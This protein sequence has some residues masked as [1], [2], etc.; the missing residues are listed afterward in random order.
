[1]A[2]S[3]KQRKDAGA[4][5]EFLQAV[6][7]G[8][9]DVIKI[10]DRDMRIQ[11]VN[12]AI[13]PLAGRSVRECVGQKC[14]EVVHGLSKP[15]S[16][17]TTMETFRTGRRFHSGEWMELKDGSRRFIEYATYPIK[18]ADGT[19]VSVVEVIRDATDKK[20]AE[21]QLLHNA[22]L[23]SL[24]E[25]AAG[26]A[27]EVRNPLNA[28]KLGLQALE[29]FVAH[30]GEAREIA[31]TVYRNVDRLAAF[32]TNMLMF[33]RKD[34]EDRIPSDVRVVVQKAVSLVQ[35]KANDQ[36]VR[37]VTRFQE[38]LGTAV[39]N[40]GQIEQV[41][42]NILL[43]AIQAMPGGGEVEV[44]AGLH[45]HG[46]QAGLLLR[47]ADTGAGIPE[48]HK[49]RVFDPFYSTKPGGTG[50]GL[51]I[52][53]KIVKDHG[54]HIAIRDQEPQGTIVEVFLP[55]EQDAP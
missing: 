16:F 6:L 47:L 27:H 18:Q 8:I 33:A 26:I 5:E 3:G 32:V 17:C 44:S 45:S 10:V 40:P 55:K 12:K 39:I 37:I 25:A 46:E 49:T 35:S 23:V 51:A 48:K 1:M 22:K 53:S 7:D 54:G 2:K 52:S 20:L 24:G 15:P 11:Y 43:N 13:E 9:D 28:I 4:S 38:G 19:V 41:V 21:E 36:N 50:L 30:D 42:V 14:H 29:P 31:A 34:P